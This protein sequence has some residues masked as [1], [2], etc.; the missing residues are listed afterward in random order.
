MF[1]LTCCIYLCCVVFCFDILFVARL[2]FVVLLCV[3]CFCFN[4]RWLFVFVFVCFASRFGVIGL[5]RCLVRLCCLWFWELGLLLRWVSFGCLFAVF[6][7]VFVVLVCGCW[8]FDCSLLV[9]GVWLG[10]ILLLCWF[11][12]CLLWFVAC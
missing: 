12:A 8:L 6:F 10:L 3:Y 1:G 4:S 9:I 7:V 5:L 11:G 2:W